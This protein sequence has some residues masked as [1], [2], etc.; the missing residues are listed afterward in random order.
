ME[1]NFCTRGEV[2]RSQF[3]D[4][5][6]KKETDRSGVEFFDSEFKITVREMGVF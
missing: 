6:V 2:I 1:V 4:V 3:V 5:C